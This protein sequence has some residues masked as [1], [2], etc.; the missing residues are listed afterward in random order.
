[1][2]ANCPNS[3]QIKIFSH[4][5]LN[6]YSDIFYGPVCGA[7]QLTRDEGLYLP[8]CQTTN[9]VIVLHALSL[10]FCNLTGN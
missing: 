2:F 7:R 3:D 10:L 6:Y 5:L 8:N 9:L 1:M 4:T